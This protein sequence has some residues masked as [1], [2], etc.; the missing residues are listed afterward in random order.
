MKIRLA[1]QKDKPAW[2]NYVN[3]DTDAAG[4]S[5]FA[6]KEAIEEAYG[7]KSYYLLAEDEGDITGVLP[8]FHFRVPF[9]SSRLIALPYC[10]VGD[11]LADNQEICHQLALEA[12]AVASRLKADALQIRSCTENLFDQTLPWQSS[13]QTGKVRMLL[14]LPDS[15][16]ALWDGFK[17]KLRSQV[18][19]AEKNGLSFRWGTMDDVS[20]FYTVF[21]K[22]M[23]ALGS[24]VHSKKWISSIVASYGEHARMGLVMKDEQPIGCGL[25]IMTDKTVSIPWASTLREFNRLS[26]NMMLYWNFLKFS[27]DNR[28]KQFDF[29]RST[30]N[31]GTYRFKKQWGATPVPLYWYSLTRSA[32]KENNENKKQLVD[33][34]Q[35]AT[36]WG[37]MPFSLTTLLGPK[38]R[39]YISL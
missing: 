8:L 9:V 12:I 13:V 29:G 20:D 4:Y 15:S 23:H 22:N 32:M 18:R 19:K 14:D 1:Q 31:E 30:L 25:I 39:K 26:P 28:M 5:L 35:I 24:P 34:E 10:D 36:L 16:E 33:R 27:A 2:D 17:S 6:W 37:K 38:L 11:I 21:S 3:S 7:F